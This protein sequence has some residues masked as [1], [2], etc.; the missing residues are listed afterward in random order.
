MS[1]QDRAGSQVRRRAGTARARSWLSALAVASVCVLGSAVPVAAATPVKVMPLG[2]SITDGFDVPGG[3]RV[4]LEDAL[5]ADG[6]AVDFVGTQRNGPAG[7]ADQQHEGHSGFRIDQL[8]AGVTSWLTEHRPDVV[9]L[10]IGTNDL[11]QENAVATAPQRVSSLIDRITGVVPSAT[12]LVSTV[13]PL[14]WADGAA[15]EPR[16]RTGLG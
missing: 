7:L 3:Y 9:L 10:M 16:R 1:D 15:G 6:L 12:V 14:G 2:D 8:A 4:D 5:Q 11:V 13:T